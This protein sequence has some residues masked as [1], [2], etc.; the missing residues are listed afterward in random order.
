MPNTLAPEPN[1]D[2]LF[3]LVT[4]RLY[5]FA[6]GPMFCVLMLL[7]VLNGERTQQFPFSIAY[8]VGLAGM[9]LSRWLDMRSGQARTAAGLPA[10]W[11]DFRKYSIVAVVVGLAALAAAN[12][13]A[14]MWNR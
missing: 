6:I 1:Y 12:A 7:G 2:S 10:T 9:P 8:L 14:F 11:G 3:Q 5:W 4:R 13:C